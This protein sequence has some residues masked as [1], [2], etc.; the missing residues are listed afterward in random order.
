ML[1]GWHG[2]IDMNLSIASRKFPVELF[3]GYFI[4]TGILSKFLFG[5]INGFMVPAGEVQGCL[6]CGCICTLASTISPVISNFLPLLSIKGSVKE[7]PLVGILLGIHHMLLAHL[8][9]TGTHKS[10]PPILTLSS[11][12]K[13]QDEKRSASVT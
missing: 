13:P 8:F 7:S 12:R 3:I 5:L 2:G 4:I 1:E 9:C 6:G 11:A 10:T